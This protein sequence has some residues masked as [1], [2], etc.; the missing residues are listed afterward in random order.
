[1][2]KE[3]PAVIAHINML[4]GIINRM[5]ENSRSCKQWCILVVSAILTIATKDT[6]LQSRLPLIYIVPVVM[7]CFLDCYYLSMEKG[8]RDD[9]KVFV[10]RLNNGEDVG[11]KIFKVD[12]GSIDSNDNDTCSIENLCIKA[13]SSVYGLIRSFF[14]WSIIPFYGCLALLLYLL[15]IL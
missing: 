4:Q 14:S 2:N 15:N 6:D 1:M 7:F 11:E 5:A 9:M 13:V 10:Y 3:N 12:K 8:F